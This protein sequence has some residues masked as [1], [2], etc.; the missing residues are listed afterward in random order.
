MEIK[1]ALVRIK[2]DGWCVVEGIIPENEVGSIRESVVKTV[3]FH[4]HSEPDE[5]GVTNPSRRGIINF[6]QSFA[7]YLANNYVMGVADE[8]WGKWV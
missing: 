3:D 6:D 2:R 7:P 4:E 5:F 8:L 1:D